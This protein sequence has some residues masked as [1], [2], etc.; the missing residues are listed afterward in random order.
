L[1]NK[2]ILGGTRFARTFKREEGSVRRVFSRYG[3]ISDENAGQ[4]GFSLIEILVVVALLG[5]ISVIMTIAVSKTLKRQRLET[6][7]HEIQSFAN[8]AYTDATSTG[9]A[10][11][12]RISAPAADGSRT[13]VLFD[14]TDND[15]KFTSGTDLQLSTQLVPGDLVVSAPPSGIASWPSPASNVFIVACDPLGR[16]VDPTL[17]NPA[18]VTGSV[19]LSI[20]HKEMGSGGDLRPNL[21]FD[22]TLNILW[23][24]TI[25]KYRNGG[26]VS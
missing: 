26:K 13:M 16:T 8:R 3:K 25:I 6:A 23:Q 9:R 15:L 20:T 4:L 10:V 1:W 2:A 14:D 22:I 11:F 12:V 17:A 7:A 24:P 21:R 5:M 18:P 19:G